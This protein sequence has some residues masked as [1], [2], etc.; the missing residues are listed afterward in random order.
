M[1]WAMKELQKLIQE[2]ISLKKDLDVSEKQ[3]INWYL[4]LSKKKG[5]PYVIK[6]LQIKIARLSSI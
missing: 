6:K 2:Y 5:L 1:H 4:R 3:L